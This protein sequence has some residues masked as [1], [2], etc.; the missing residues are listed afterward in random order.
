MFRSNLTRG[1]IH[2]DYAATTPVDPVVLDEMLPYF[3]NQFGNAGSRIYGR[4]LAAESAVEEARRRVA[5]LIGS[6]PVEISFTGGATESNNLALLGVA[7]AWD[8]VCHVLV[9]SIEHPSVR[10]VAEELSRRGV[11]VHYLPVASDGRVDPDDLSRRLTKLQRRNDIRSGRIL[12]SVMHANNETGVIQ[13]IER[14]AAICHQFGA[15]IHTDA[16]Q[17][18]GK[19]PVDVQQLGVDL[20][21]MSGHKLYGPKGVG[22]LFVRRGKPKIEI[23]NQVW[24]GSQERGLRSGTTNV[25]GI[26]GLG[27]ACR[28]ASELM[29]GEAIEHRR[30]TELIVA[31]LSVRL[32][33]VEVNGA[34]AN[35]LPGLVSLSFRGVS[36]ERLQIALRNEVEVSTT[37]ACSTGSQEPSPV[38]LAMGLSRERAMETLR[39]AVGRPTC[40]EDVHLAMDSIVRV[41]ERFSM[42]PTH[43]RRAVG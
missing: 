27:A 4:G 28:R 8:S 23:Q 34:L 36:A 14:L 33:G 19:V 10:E 40:E 32:M 30:L 1:P 12:V 22:A 20:L 26:V 31:C 37:S 18:V 13:P 24:G 29:I 39:I 3:S 38:L 43:R 25:P 16:S 21:S 7:S 11:T 2:L 35:R 15:L 5:D 6:R 41:V 9:S 42:K 17:C